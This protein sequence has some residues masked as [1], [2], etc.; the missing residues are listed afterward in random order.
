MRVKIIKLLIGLFLGSSG[1]FLYLTAPGRYDAGKPAAQFSASAR[2]ERILAEAR[3]GANV[4]ENS[5]VAYRTD[6]AT[7]NI[8]S[9]GAIMMVKSK[10][11]EGVAEDPQGMMDMLT[12]MSGSNKKK[13]PPVYL[14]DKDLDKKIIIEHSGK[15]AAPLSASA[16]PGL[17]ESSSGMSGKTMISAPVDYKTFKDL[18]TW[19]AFASTHKGH[20]PPVDFSWEEM[21]ILVSVS[22]LPSG[23]FKIDGLKR[24]VKETVVLYRVDPL[25]M[26]AENEKKEQ[27]FYS[28]ITIPKNIDV[29][30]EQIP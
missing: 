20:F 4:K 8:R 1:V 3:A 11:F 25:A 7:E 5:P 26:A 22:D 9:E 15:P 28:A 29:K 19:M 10:E 27:N 24:S 21:L 16:V 23:I 13:K 6:F 30:L 18:E 14:T 2:A 12:E 17:G